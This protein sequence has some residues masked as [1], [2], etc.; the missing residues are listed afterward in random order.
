V[1]FRSLLTAAVLLSSTPVWAA[2]SSDLEV[3]DTAYLF[4]YFLGN[5]ESGL[6]LAWSRDGL[7]WESLNR[8]RSMLQPQ[9]GRSK[10][11]R[12]PCIIQ[13]PDGRFHMVWTDSW[14]S[15]TIGY[16]WSRDLIEW[17]EQKAIPVMEH[18]PNAK[19]CWAPELV[20]DAKRD[21]FII[22]WATTIPEKFTETWMDGR[23]DNNH[24]LYATTT[25]DF[26]SFTPTAL[27]F[28]PGFN[29]IDSTI[30]A[31]G[32][33]FHMVF[34]DERKVPQPRKNLLLAVADDIAGPYRV[35][36]PPV[37]Q[38]GSEW[39]EGPSLL[40]VDEWFYLYFDVYGRGR[41]DVLRTRDWQTW[42]DVSA[43][44]S[45]P[46]GIRHGTALA[47]PGSV[48][49]TLLE[50]DRAPRDPLA[51]RNPIVP[52]RADPH[53]TLHTDGYYYLAATV[54][55][56]DRLELRR[57][58]TLGGLSD[59]DAVT[60]WRKR[61]SGP[62][63]HHIWAPE[64]HF[65]DGKWYIYFAAGRAEAIWDIR[66]YVLENASANP[67]EG[68]WVAKGQVDSGWESF[69]L[70]ATTFEHRGERYYVWTQRGRSGEGRGTNLYIAKMD[71]PW[72]MVGPAVMVSRPEFEWER[73]GHWVNEAPSVLIRN[74]RIFMTYSAS[75]TDANY[76]LGL[77]TASEDADLLESASWS[78]S[79]EPVFASSDATSQYG[80]GHNSFT[81]TPD[82][83]TDLIVY[84]ARNYRDIRGEPLNNPDRATRAQ[85]IR[86]RPDG[87]PDF[88]VPV[89]DGLYRA[90]PLV[91]PDLALSE[92][93]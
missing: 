21:Q 63:S 14:D 67:L 89:A 68:E 35:V 10:L 82:G 80:P 69:A 32:D 75:A 16:A 6:H 46:R 60:V 78:K 50:R 1:I 85:V 36:E 19:N 17:S 26:E 76:C 61:E 62:M 77:L 88:G 9:V 33:R 48:V 92:A 81:T 93:R 20:Y 23:D 91:Q 59:A 44:L 56:Y 2:P 40:Q 29:A 27:F 38:P 45:M 86:W 84:H 66:M 41:Y 83:Q 65:I 79:P 39:V 11:M 64:L 22:F 57:A 42:E 49:Q 71:T 87:T 28:D 15:K 72:S 43:Q 73:R 54:P 37:T 53:V 58:T 47:V 70:D 30:L 12:D 31:V 3:P 74:G 52:Q 25:K 51:W 55:A 4:S 34:K 7:K 5:G 18:E 13:G 90:G 24:R 8:G